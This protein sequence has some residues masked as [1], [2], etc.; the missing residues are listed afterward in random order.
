MKFFISVEETRSTT[1]VVEADT[2]E[3]A[4]LAV[5]DAYCRDEIC[6]DNPDCI[7]GET[8][9]Y[10]VTDRY[11]PDYAHKFQEVKLDDH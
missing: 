1:V 9:F 10:D 4:L 3:N 6:L 7:C 11:S 5:E 2:F 8:E